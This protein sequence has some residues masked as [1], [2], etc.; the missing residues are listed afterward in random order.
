MPEEPPR[1]RIDLLPRDTAS[2][3]KRVRA[4]GRLLDSRFAI[5]GTN[6]RF[7]LDALLGLIPGVGDLAAALPSLYLLFEARR[8]GMPA[9]ILLRMAANILVDFAVGSVPVA[10]DVFDVLYKANQR[11]VRLLERELGKQLQA[12]DRPKP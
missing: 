1:V 5:P 4:L 10:G 6:V 11:N 3:L 2:A 8:L 7:G 12:G 9:H